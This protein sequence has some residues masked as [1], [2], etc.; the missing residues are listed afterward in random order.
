MLSFGF[1]NE[2]LQGITQVAVRDYLHKHLQMVFAEA[3][4]IAPMPVADAT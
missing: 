2:L 1:I 3:D 4:S